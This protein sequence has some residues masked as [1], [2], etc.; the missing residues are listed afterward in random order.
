MH[1]YRSGA[2]HR[3]SRATVTEVHV[4]DGGAIVYDIRY[5]RALEGSGGSKAKGREEVEEYD[6]EARLLRKATAQNVTAAAAAATTVTWAREPKGNHRN[7]RSAAAAAADRDEEKSGGEEDEL[8]WRVKDLAT[9]QKTLPSAL[10]SKYT[11]DILVLEPDAYFFLL[12]CVRGAWSGACGGGP[13][14]GSFPGRYPV[15]PRH[16]CKRRMAPRRRR[17]RRRSVTC[18]PRPRRR[19]L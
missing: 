16:P 14:R 6:V 17:W 13:R 3:W 15:V 7:R 9:Q 8:L 5:H 2:A 11:R 18:F 12:A 10:W 4:V 19:W 1:R